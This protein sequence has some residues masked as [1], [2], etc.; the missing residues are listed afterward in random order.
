MTRNGIFNAM[1]D[2]IIHAQTYANPESPELYRG[3]LGEEDEPSSLKH[4]RSM[5]DRVADSISSE[6]AFSTGKM[7]RWLGFM[8][9]VL[10]SCGIATLNEVKDVNRRHK[11][12]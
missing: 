4:L 9:G 1:N 5:Y 11:D 6:T 8:Q 7:N 10:V 12:D 2:C 3:D